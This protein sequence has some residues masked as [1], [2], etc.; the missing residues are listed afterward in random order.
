MAAPTSERTVRLSVLDRLLDEPDTGR[1]VTWSDSVHQLRM[2]IL[3]DVEWLLNTRR[4]FEKAPATYPEV[5]RSVYHYGIP[6]VSSM[7]HNP[8]TISVHLV[9]HL[10]EAIKLFEPRLMSVRVVPSEAEG[11]A[12]RYTVE[13]LLRMDPNPERIVFDTVLEPGRGEFQITESDDA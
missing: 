1:A 13:A 10:E 8:E 12:V 6:D 5:Q 9:R 3:R 11:R 2:S 4:I 7:S